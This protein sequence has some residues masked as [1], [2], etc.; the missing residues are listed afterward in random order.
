[1]ASPTTAEEID[2]KCSKCEKELDTDGT[3]RWCKACRA[4]YQREYQ[5]LKK[6]MSETRGFAAGCSAMRDFMATYFQQFGNV[7]LS[8]F[9]VAQMARKAGMPQ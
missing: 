9:E 7:R 8:G 2:L 6:E 5:S 3:P 1:M 4:K